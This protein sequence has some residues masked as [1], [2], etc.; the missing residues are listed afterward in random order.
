MKIEEGRVYTCD[1]HSDDNS[2]LILKIGSA[3]ECGLEP[4]FIE[5]IDPDMV[6]VRWKNDKRV[7]GY[8]T[9]HFIEH[10]ARREVN[11]DGNR[12]GR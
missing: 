2:R 8:D 1:R 11:D 3:L 9:L 5:F 10:W 7:E 4:K 6:W 12:S